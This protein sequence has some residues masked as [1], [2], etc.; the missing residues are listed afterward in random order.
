MSER[1]PAFGRWLAIQGV[2]FA[3]VVTIMLGILIEAGRLPLGGDVPRWVGY[4]LAA[5]GMVEVFALPRLL[6]QRWKSPPR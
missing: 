5:I 4:V 6:A 3:G 2:R 1:D